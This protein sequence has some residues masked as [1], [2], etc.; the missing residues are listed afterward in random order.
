MKIYHST[1]YDAFGDI[2]IIDIYIYSTI[3]R[4]EDI[5]TQI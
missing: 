1:I 4:H 3:I 5:M 2:N